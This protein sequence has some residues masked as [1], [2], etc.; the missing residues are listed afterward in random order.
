MSSLVNNSIRTVWTKFAA[1]VVLLFMSS[2]TSADALVVIV[3]P[4]SGAG[5]MTRNEVANIYMARTR[6]LVPGV[7]AL[8]LDVAGDAR[9]RRLFYFALVGKTIPEVNAYWAR[10]L[11]TGR[12]TPP[13]Q[14]DDEAGVLATV[15]ENKGAIGYV[16]K[17]K[18]DARVKVVLELTP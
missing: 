9:E 18:V 17:S 13:H 10:L 6:T 15:A 1:V 7:I 11:F 16:S 2:M 3:N 14:V 4:A 5:Q 12:A 8:P